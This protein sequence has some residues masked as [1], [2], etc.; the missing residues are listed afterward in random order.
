MH[1][2]VVGEAAAEVRDDRLDALGEV[3][4]VGV[5]R[6]EALH[7]GLRLCRGRGAIDA[8]G[9]AACDHELAA[10][11]YL[12]ATGNG[13]GINGAPGY[14]AANAIADDLGLKR[15]WTRV[16]LPEWRQ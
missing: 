14:I 2:I 15:P 13:G 1:H 11:Q 3:S 10:D 12:V 8:D 9:T 4:G 7:R 5:R 6:G 16:P